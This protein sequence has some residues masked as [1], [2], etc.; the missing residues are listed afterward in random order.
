MDGDK[1]FFASS[2][3]RKKTFRFLQ[4]FLILAAYFFG[5]RHTVDYLI[6]FEPVRPFFQSDVIPII[7]ALLL[8]AYFGFL[9]FDWRR[10]FPQRSGHEVF[11]AYVLPE[12]LIVGF[13]LIAGFYK[14][15]W[16]AIVLYH[17]TFWFLAPFFSQR[18]TRLK[19]LTFSYVLPTIAIM[20]IA[21][22][23][24]PRY[25]TGTLA[26]MPFFGYSYNGGG[27]LG[28]DSYVMTTEAIQYIHGTMNWGTVHIWL[29]LS[30]STL[31]PQFI[32]ALTN[33]K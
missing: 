19:D 26:D 2:A 25:L 3:I 5:T 31:N 10:I 15:H 1:E 33:R 30:L 27:F 7:L 8:I 29:S 32:N 18:Q 23:Y 22:W 4:T 14:F 16:V 17:I 11:S 6:G 20:L 24:Y 9:A 12:A 28:F 21:A 13:C